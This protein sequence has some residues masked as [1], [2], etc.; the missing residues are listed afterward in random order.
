M[1]FA[2]RRPHDLGRFKWTIDAK[3]PLR[4]TAQEKWWKDTLGPLQEARC[5]RQPFQL[6]KGPDFNYS[7]FEKAFMFEKM[8]WNPDKPREPIVG[9]D[10]KGILSDQITFIDSRLDIMIQCVDILANFARRI[11]TERTDD[12]MIAQ[13]LGRLQIIRSPTKGMPQSISILTITSDITRRGIK[14]GRLINLMSL[15]GRSMLRPARRPKP[16]RLP[17]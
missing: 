9:Y 17:R 13:C 7:S 8:L 11:L 10:I 15:A 12:P 2:Q 5:R 3:D 4:V 1:Y 14:Q 6:V 16:S